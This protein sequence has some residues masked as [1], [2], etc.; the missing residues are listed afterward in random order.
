MNYDEIVRA[1]F[2]LGHALKKGTKPGDA[3]GVMLPTGTASILSFYA[4]SAYGRVP[5]MLNFT[6][7]SAGLKSALR[8]AQ[9]QPHR[10]SAQIHRTRQT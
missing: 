5:A 6:T 7:G 8:T 3:I 1:A 4:L 9:V 2:A 10:H